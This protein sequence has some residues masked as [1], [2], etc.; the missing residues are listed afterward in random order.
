V[1]EVETEVETLKK[2]DL[3]QVEEVETEVETLKKTEQHSPA[4]KDE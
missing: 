3:S 2:T 4:K 1:E